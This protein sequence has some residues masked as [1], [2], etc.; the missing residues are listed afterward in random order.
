MWQTFYHQFETYFY[1]NIIATTIPTDLEDTEIPGFCIQELDA[2]VWTLSL[3]AGSRML[4]FGYWT[5]DARLWT[6]DDGQS[7]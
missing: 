3:D 5:L 1:M 2:E 6:M 7:F 4:D